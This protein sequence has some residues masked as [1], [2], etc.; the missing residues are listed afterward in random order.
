VSV[1]TALP[2]PDGVVCATY[3]RDERDGLP[4]ADRLLP[5]EGWAT[6]TIATAALTQL[7]GWLV[8]APAGPLSTTLLAAGAVRRR[9]A[10]VLRLD[11][12]STA[13]HA[14]APLPRG[15]TLAPLSAGAVPDA[16]GAVS[17]AA[18]PPG[19]PDAGPGETA[20]TALAELRRI[21]AGEVIGP[22][23]PASALALRDGHPV[24]AVFVNVRPGTGPWI[25][26]LFRLPGREGRGLGAALLAA[27]ADRVRRAGGTTIGLAVTDGNPARTL[28]EAR[29][30]VLFESAMTLLLPPEDYP[31]P[32]GQH[33]SPAAPADAG[34]L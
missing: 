15:V 30:Y 11:L 1:R 10:H 33:R 12:A 19:H 13:A 28:Y 25:T 21:A 5:R 22:L 16:L 4:L 27:T 31:C 3:V 18:Y 20:A 24:G 34:G 23:H 9:Y 7:P 6:A 17:L 2:G 26:E 14:P 8:T 32:G 29:G